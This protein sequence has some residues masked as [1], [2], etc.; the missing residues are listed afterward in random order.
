MRRPVSVP[1][2]DGGVVSELDVSN[3]TISCGRIAVSV[4]SRDPKS[5]LSLYV[6]ISAR[7]SAPFP[8]TSDV[9]L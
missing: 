3:V 5:T 1:G 9:A 2:A 8:F 4:S 6:E 7:L